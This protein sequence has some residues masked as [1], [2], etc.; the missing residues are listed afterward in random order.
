V[1]ASNN[2][3]S[4]NGGVL[5]NKDQTTL[6]TYPGGKSGSSYSIPNSVTTIGS[7]AFF[8]SLNLISIAIPNTVT[9]I[10]DYAFYGRTNI[11]SVTFS[12]SI[13]Q[14]YF[15]ATSSFYGNLRA[16]YLGEGGGP[17]TYTTPGPTVSNSAIWTKQGI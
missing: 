16:V 15:S 7:R 4:D 5:F 2:Y 10:G 11:I 6:V 8:Y 14:Q 13:E 12:G 17:G 1:D 9:A 3:Y